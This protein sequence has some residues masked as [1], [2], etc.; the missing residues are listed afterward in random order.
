MQCCISWF[1]CSSEE[2]I[3][4]I[5]LELLLFHSSFRLCLPSVPLCF[6]YNIIH[7]GICI[8]NSSKISLTLSLRGDVEI[9]RVS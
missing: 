3:F 1:R 5:R 6:S 7:F 9:T 8:S 4:C 2:P